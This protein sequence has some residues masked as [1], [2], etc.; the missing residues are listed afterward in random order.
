MGKAKSTGWKLPA[1][2]GLGLVLMAA[3]GPEVFSPLL[4]LVVFSI[5][6]LLFMGAIGIAEWRWLRQYKRQRITSTS[7]IL[8][9]QFL[10]LFVIGWWT[11]DKFA[12]WETLFASPKEITAQDIAREI[13][14]GDNFCFF[15]LNSEGAD[16]KDGAY[17]LNWNGVG[18][19]KSVNYWISPA[20]SKPTTDPKDPYY[21]IDHRKPLRRIVHEGVR[22]STRSLPPGEYNIAFDAE[23]GTWSQY[24]RIY[25]QDG[26]VRQ[27]IEV[28]RN[29]IVI[30][31]KSKE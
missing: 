25:I 2:G 5:G 14:G 29:G 24:F 26:K 6:I 20:S 8:L 21:S 31:P 10:I 11:V 18:I 17:Q 28:K 12:I 19:V 7:L 13:R 1:F 22:A 3:F 23:N 30:Y 4:R 16:A 27:E 9:T 15:S